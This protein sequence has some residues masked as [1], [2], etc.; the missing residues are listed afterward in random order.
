MLRKIT[1]FLAMFIFFAAHAQFEPDSV[2]NVNANEELLVEH[3]SI[4]HVN[5][6]I[7]EIDSAL[8][9]REQFI[10]DSLL[11]RAKFVQDSLLARAK[12]VKDSVNLLQNELPRL[13][14][15][16]L[17][18]E[19]EEIILSTNDVETIGDSLLGNF[20]YRILAQNMSSPYAPWRS[21][22]ILSENEI[23][24]DVDTT[25]KVVNKLKMKKK[26]Y[27]FNYNKGAKIVQIKGKSTII[28]KRT[29][30][31]YK[32]PI[33][34]VFFDENNR[35]KLIK[36][37]VHYFEATKQYKKGASLYLDIIKVKKFKYF[38]DGIL[39]YYQVVTYCDRWDGRDDANEQCNKVTYSVKRDGK[40][41]FIKKHNE[42]E[43][44]YSDGT[45]VFE[46]D[47][48]FDLKRIEFK[49]A[50][51][52]LSRTCLVELNEDRNVVKYSYIKEGM[53]KRT[54]D[55]IYNND[56]NADYKY[57]TITSHFKR[58][59]VCHFQKNNRTGKTRQRHPLTLK[60]S[61]WK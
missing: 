53:V 29:G 38:N 55:I 54:L 42:P 28:R 50:D 8:I 52:N 25:N 40:T 18:S 27:L 16:I 9:L 34:S 11:A 2:Q 46:F 13:I 7:A 43:N 30:N 61:E 57:E 15:A 33:D 31:F 32:I 41:F 17:K 12:F 4:V 19:N 59:R 26:S 21:K 60:W 5:D 1:T 35:V 51:K 37:Y 10:R 23:K 14:T 58:D 48:N 39:S 22:I 36:S 24:V 3:D 49:G 6:S 56:P 20:T 44:K 45:L 47:D